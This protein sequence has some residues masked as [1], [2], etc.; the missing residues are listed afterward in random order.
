MRKA[1]DHQTRLDCR[2]VFDVQLNLDC[3][4][5][6]VPILKALQHIY[7]QPKL[8]D[9]ILRAIARDVN[10]DSSRKQG[11][12]GMDYWQILVLTFGPASAMAEP[13][14]LLRTFVTPFPDQGGVFGSKIAVVGDNV[15]VSDWFANDH[16]G[17]VSLFWNTLGVAYYGAESWKAAIDALGKSLEL[18]GHNG[19]DFL[20]LAMAHWQ[21]GQKDKARQWYQKAVERMEKNR[22]ERMEKSRLWDEELRRFQAE[23]AE[24]LEIKNEQP[25]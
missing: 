9:D 3:R 10:H 6:I 16:A 25:E 8:R 24:L 23:A 13:G 21:L 4:D 7:S 11:R 17:A 5:E 18:Q 14:D 1:F 12:Q 22:P 15:L 2:P 19:C 20:F